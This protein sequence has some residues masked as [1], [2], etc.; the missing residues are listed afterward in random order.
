MWPALRAAGYLCI[1]VDPEKETNT[2]VV[3]FPVH[4]SLFVRSKTDV[5]IWEQVELAAQLQRDWADNQVSCTV[6]FKPEEAKDIKHV[7]DMYDYK[8]KG[9]SFLPLEDHGYEHAPYQEITKE[10]YE[11]YAASVTPV[12]RFDTEAEV[13]NLFCDSDKCELPQ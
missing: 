4:E 7:L 5:S 13:M 3:Y 1:D 6:T 10:E 9:I 8:L 2:T 11:A 12:D